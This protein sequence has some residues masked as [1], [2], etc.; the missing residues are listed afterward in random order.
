MSLSQLNCQCTVIQYSSV[1]CSCYCPRFY[2]Y[3]NTPGIKLY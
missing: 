1:T 3:H 2:S